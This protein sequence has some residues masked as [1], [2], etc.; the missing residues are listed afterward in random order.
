[1][2]FATLVGGFIVILISV[3]AQVCWP[4][5]QKSRKAFEQNTS[6]TLSE[7]DSCNLLLLEAAEV[8]DAM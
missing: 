5:L 1:M 3:L 8:C 7:T 6:V 4:H 2:I